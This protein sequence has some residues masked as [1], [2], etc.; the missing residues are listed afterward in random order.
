[1][2]LRHETYSLMLDHIA[3]ENKKLRDEALVCLRSICANR[4][5]STFAFTAGTQE[6]K[7]I[8]LNRPETPRTLHFNPH[9]DY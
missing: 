9:L 5:K 6:S 2:T 3:G 8:H 4:R 1:M 7:L